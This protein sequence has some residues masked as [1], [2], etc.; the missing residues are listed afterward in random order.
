M[1]PEMMTQKRLHEVMS[2]NEKTGLFYWLAPTSNRVKVGELAGSVDHEGYVRIKVD[3]RRYRAHRLAW[4]YV[5][6]KFPSCVIDHINGD[7]SDNRISNIRDVTNSVNLQ[8]QRRAPSCSHS[9]LIGAHVSYK[10]SFKSSINISGKTVPLGRF[11]TAYLA[12][13]AYITMKRK[14]HEGCTI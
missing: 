13:E 2:Y 14:Y 9:G 7:R 3:G 8:N 6:G 1:K 11:P 5:H 10:G 12:H 4:L